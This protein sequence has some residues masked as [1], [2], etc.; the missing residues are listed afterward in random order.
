VLVGSTEKMGVGTNVQARAVALHHLDCPWRPSDI[1]QREGRLLRQGNQNPDV[2]IVRYVTQGSFD[3]YT[4]QTVERKAVFIHQVSRGQVTDREIDD[5]GDQALSASQVKALATGNP[6]IME[7]AGVEA[8]L[9][10]LE[11]LARAHQRE[12]RDLTHRRTAAEERAARLD[13]QADLIDT[14]LPR[15]VDTRADRFAM[16]VADRRYTRRIDAGVALRAHLLDLL[17]RRHLG[18]T[19]ARRAGTVT[20]PVG[21]L[22]GLHLEADITA[23]ADMAAYGELR[24]EDLPVRPLP[25]ERADLVHADPAGLVAKLENRILGLDDTAATLRT[26]AALARTEATAT[27]ARIGRPFEHDHH[28]QQLRHRLA[29]IDDALAPADP[30]RPTEADTTATAISAAARNIATDP[31]PTT[32]IGDPGAAGRA[33]DTGSSETNPGRVPRAAAPGSGDLSVHAQ[34]HLYQRAAQTLTEPPPAIQ[35]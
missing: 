34:H 24:V 21:T 29:A 20:H 18:E 28:L 14:A 17:D 8:D 19:V 3:V 35:A 10:K 25:L 4:W 9:T 6:L 27:S 5:I 31:A 7:R 26:D 16:T 32:L 13:R 15:R 22:G 23:L 1:D 33:A 2:Q 30:P 11:R 12:Q